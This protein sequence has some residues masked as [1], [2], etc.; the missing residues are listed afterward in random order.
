[1]IVR[2]CT[3]GLFL[4][5]YVKSLVYADKPESIDALEEKVQ[6]II[7]DIWPQLL[8]YIRASRGRNMPEITFKTQWQTFFFTIELNFW[9]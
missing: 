9:P 5:G 3:A 2:L 6:G 1:M 8:E 4:C 7:A